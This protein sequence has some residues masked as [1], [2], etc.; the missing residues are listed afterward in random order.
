M[1]EFMD[2]VSNLTAI[3]VLSAFNG[4]VVTSKL[5]PASAP[6]VRTHLERSFKVLSEFLVLGN[7][8]TIGR[9]EQKYFINGR[10]LTEDD[11]AKITNLVL[12]RQLEILGLESLTLEHGLDQFTYRQ[13]ITVFSAKKEKINRE[14]GGREFVI[15]LGISSCFPEKYIQVQTPSSTQSSRVLRV[16]P[17][18]LSALF[19]SSVKEDS[20]ETL[21]KNLN[22]PDGGAELV[23]AG[24]GRLLLALSK[25][26]DCVRVS[27]F[28]TMLT[29]VDQ[30]IEEEN[31]DVLAKKLASILVP[32]LREQAFSILFYQEYPTAFGSILYAHLLR[33]VSDEHLGRILE[34]YTRYLRQ[35][36]ALGAPRRAAITQEVIGALQQ[37]TRVKAYLAKKKTEVGI[38]Y[39]ELERLQ[40]RMA[41]SLESLRKKDFRCL[42]ND[43]FVSHLP[44]LMSSYADHNKEEGVEVIN[45]L[46][47]ALAQ[48][49]GLEKNRLVTF[50]LIIG[51]N[52]LKKKKW[53]MLSPILVACYT[54]MKTS[55][56]A[57]SVY[58][59]IATLLY[60]AGIEE[61]ALERHERA[62]SILSLF[63]GIRSGKIPQN[64]AVRALVSR[65]Q[66]SE[67]D[68]RFLPVM[69]KDYLED[70]DNL[71]TGKRLLYQGKLGKRY[72]IDILIRSEQS[73][74]RLK[75]ID[76]LAQSS[77]DVSE[78]VI[79]RLAEDMQWFGKRNLLKVL[80]ETGDHS[81]ASETLPYIQHADI[82]VQREAYLCII[83]IGGKETKNLL[84]EAL[85]VSNDSVKAQI[86][87]SLGEYEEDEVISALCAQLKKCETDPPREGSGILLQLLSSL[88][89]F[90]SEKALTGLGSFIDSRKSES[91]VKYDKSIFDVAEKARERVVLACS[92]KK[93][94]H[95]VHV[96]TLRKQSQ[97]QAAKIAL[98]ANSAGGC[99][100]DD[101]SEPH[102]RELVEQGQLDEAGHLFNTIIERLVARKKFGQAEKVREWLIDVCPGLLASIIHAAEI[103][104]GAKNVSIKKEHL[105]VWGDLY[106]VLTTEEFSALYHSLQHHSLQDSQL[107]VRQGAYQKSLYFINQ[108]K[109][110]LSYSTGHNETHI[111]TLGYGTVLG[112]GAFFDSSVWTMSVHCLGRTEIS[113]L[114]FDDI[115]RL[116]E[117]HP[118]LESKLRDF[119]VKFEKLEVY[120]TQSSKDRRAYPRVNGSG[121]VAVQLIDSKGRF[122]GSMPKG[123]LS[124]ISAGGV[125]FLSRLSRKENARILLGRKV[126]VTLP[127]KHDDE[128]DLICYGQVLG[129]RAVS[130][131][132]NE[133][134][135]HIKFD[136]LI[137][138]KVFDKIVYKLKRQQKNM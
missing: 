105:E 110:N 58:E 73:D 134:S 55:Q 112:A 29:R 76:L 37:S 64:P 77:E 42:A 52:L 9:V 36:E 79:E 5:Y 81:V 28:A 99:I 26:K 106:D 86:I 85:A 125:S 122:V 101:K 67:F 62:D 107:V 90:S 118:A 15:D 96:S 19:G 70:S 121:R 93:K 32:N 124:D 44:Q 120:F 7:S 14:G 127:I 59:K 138:N 111:T 75:I 69:L 12:Y 89:N 23:A 109:V 4:A 66:D 102:L 35:L 84:L 17:H 119:C 113:T 98:Q 74:S 45:L 97:R 126:Q 21:Q 47:V 20:I 103:I 82:R 128:S 94:Q 24:I 92:E 60:R 136:K 38:A 56:V 104:E 33:A 8:F 68:R 91:K 80:A 40:K 88:S 30:Y 129:I 87:K 132:E 50:L 27:E 6:Q 65:V 115:E 72:L 25:K 108:G 18:L 41:V 10:E 54:W 137:E 78:I 133:Y 39:G 11:V 16:P 49:V 3:E 95:H 63:Y 2:K 114:Q 116:T 61:R 22:C 48:F 43:E 34:I 131:I 100:S 71:I 51:D 57:D 123:D 83:K 117:E 31:K 1:S 135:I 46:C 130:G 53:R 13:I